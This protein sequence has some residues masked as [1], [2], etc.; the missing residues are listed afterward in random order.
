MLAGSRGSFECKSGRLQL[1]G[2]RPISTATTDAAGAHC[3]MLHQASRELSLLL[4]SSLIA[5]AQL[6]DSFSASRNA[7]LRSRGSFWK[8]TDQL[9]LQNPQTINRLRIFEAS[10]RPTTERPCP[11]NL[12]ALGNPMSVSVACWLT[13][14]C[15]H[16]FY[17][18]DEKVTL[19]VLVKDA[20]ADKVSV[21]FTERS[22]ST[23][24]P[25]FQSASNERAFC[26][27]SSNTRITSSRSRH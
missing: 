20:Q 6:D 21:K 15:R 4:N 24:V 12:S 19:S 1:E 25:A 8:T 23:S 2:P 3:C 10:P 7:T 16:Q 11:S 5:S 27:P 26:R 18:T 9:V 22:V 17:E 13:G 14:D